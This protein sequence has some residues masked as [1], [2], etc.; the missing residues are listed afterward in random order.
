MQYFG[1]A[2]GSVSK[3]W[4]SINPATLSGAIDVIVVEDEEGEMR[5][6]PFHVRF[7]K[8]QL[9]RPSQ[10]K[11]S[12]IVNGEITDIPMKLSDEGEAF[13]VFETDGYVPE[14]LQTSPV[15]SARSSPS[16]SPRLSPSSAGTNDE[17][18]YLDIG[19]GANDTTNVTVE[20]KNKIIRNYAD[21]SSLE[22]REHDERYSRNG[23]MSPIERA[24]SITMKLNIPSKVEANGDI[25]L[26]MHGYKSDKKD[27]KETDALVRQLL[28]E[29]FGD[30]FDTANMLNTD[31]EGN[32]R[33]VNTEGI[34]SES[35]FTSGF[36]EPEA[37]SSATSIP[38]SPSR[39][40]N[41]YDEG[42]GETPSPVIKSDQAKGDAISQNSSA[43]SIHVPSSSPTT[44]SSADSDVHHDV[45]YKTLRLTS[46]QLKCL[47][48]NYGENDIKYNVNNGKSIVT[49]KL[50]LWKRSTP[51]VIS[52]I[53]GTITRS[54]A[55]GHVLTMLGRDW[56]H[57]GVAKLFD[58]IEFNGYNI[59]Y[60]TARSVG[61]ADTTRAY[62]RGVE[63]NDIKLPMGPVILSPDRTIAALKR[64]IVLKK[65]EV[66][67]MSCL[68][69]IRT[70]YYPE[71]TNPLEH[72]QKHL[73]ENYEDDVSSGDESG[74]VATGGTTSITGSGINS[75]TDEYKLRTGDI[76]GT[77]GDHDDEG[78]EFT[79]LNT[80]TDPS[81]VSDDLMM[82]F[83]DMQLKSVVDESS[84]PF[85]AGFGNRITDAISY[86]S[87]GVPSSRIFTINPDGDVRMELLEMAGYKSSY[88]SIV[89]LVDQFFPPVDIRQTQRSKDDIE[90]EKP[91]PGSLQMSM[92]N[93]KNKYTDFTYWRNPNIDLSLITDDE[94][95]SGD[96]QEGAEDG[97]DKGKG[98]KS[99]E[100]GG[101]SDKLAMKGLEEIP[102]MKLV[103]DGRPSSRENVDE[104]TTSRTSKASR[105][106]FF[107]RSPLSSPAKQEGDGRND[108]ANDANIT[109]RVHTEVNRR[110]ADELHGSG[111][112]PATGS[113]GEDI[114]E[115]EELEE[116]EEPEEPYSEE[117][118]SD[119]DYIYETSGDEDEGDEDEDEDDDE[120]E[121][122]SAVPMPVPMPVPAAV[123]IT[124]SSSSLSLSSSSPSSSAVSAT[125]ASGRFV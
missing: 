9:L 83:E 28:Q 89:E 39:G 106:S 3:T 124:G 104:D 75:D 40:D 81:K 51:I 99:I 77:N 26:D 91:L 35:A 60:L 15:V 62:L 70:L 8:F 121:D 36:L 103:S 37:S 25:L 65:P 12:V 78:S 27:I 101:N 86:R 93:A 102:N 76:N 110:L 117:E 120:Y 24:R 67:K 71:K 80:S 2:I 64:E 10:K 108:A 23:S 43:V 46:E 14:Y 13:F 21:K 11:V 49:C 59:M 97:D 114:G 30:D 96:G 54:D 7:G 4:N 88:V 48:L 122:D 109:D 82:K 61:L 34:S 38:T 72:D 6:S 31:L 22:S 66:F 94:D 63:Q 112:V 44:T 57:E 105:F 17:L 74:R 20:D 68:N 50:Y 32:I 84:T 52:D 92:S 123:P 5:C 56:T 87:V 47:S 19:E 125:R 53:D 45:H 107:L 18:E 113:G 115:E 85:Y 79:D 41:A 58:D 111:N 1:R 98:R 73:F 33:I 116:L 90:K 95:E 29:E 119:S 16:T 118:E 69:D 100:I 42:Q 55:L